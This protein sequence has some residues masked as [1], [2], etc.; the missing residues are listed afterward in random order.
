MPVIRCPMCGKPFDPAE[1]K[2]M[3]FC[4]ERCRRIDLGR[5][6]DEGYG[7]PFDRAEDER[8]DDNRP[9]DLANND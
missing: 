8:P 1:S 2:A 3:P 4:S 5:W 6:L 9:D 7:L